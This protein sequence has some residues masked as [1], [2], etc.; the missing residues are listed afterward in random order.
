MLLGAEVG[1]FR[2]KLH[3]VFKTDMLFMFLS[4]VLFYVIY[5]VTLKYH[6]V[7][8]IQYFSCFPLLTTMFFMYKI[9]MSSLAYRVFGNRY[10]NFIIRFVGGLCLEIYLVQG[11]L[12]TDSM[13]SIF[14]LNI[15]IMFIIIVCAAYIVRCFSRFI[16]QT[17][18]DESYNWKAMVSAID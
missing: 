3:S 15:P 14:P 12:F 13:N 10:F 4:I 1:R 16:L 7:I 18:R 2:S 17:F 9:G 6:S 11:Y 5:I 8:W